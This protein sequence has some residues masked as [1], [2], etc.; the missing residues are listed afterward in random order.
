MF[1]IDAAINPNDMD[2]VQIGKEKSEKANNRERLQR[3]V[4]KG[5]HEEEMTP[6][7]PPAAYSPPGDDQA[8]PYKE[9]HPLLQE[10]RDE[11]KGCLEELDAF[12]SALKALAEDAN[13]SNNGF[14]RMFEYMNL[15]LV[16]H[17]RKEETLL[18]P[19]LTKRLVEN[20]EHSNG[21]K[22]ITGVDVLEAD[23]LNLHQLAAVA[24]NFYQLAQ[25]LPADAGGAFV[26]KTAIQQGKALIEQLRLHIF[27]E[28]DVY[29]SLAHKLIT[30][31]ELDA[32]YADR[33]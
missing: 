18:F 24:I 3:I 12:E 33:R 32:M 23:H 10:L 28:D 26:R 14:Q 17:N 5:D 6:W 1:L 27:R 21:P 13:A 22:A 2:L 31:E 30:T 29:F 19:L 15:E 9:M 7:D 16:F 8:V 20:G 25:R 4:E 11:H